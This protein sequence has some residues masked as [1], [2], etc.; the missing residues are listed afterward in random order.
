MNVFNRFA[1]EQ[2]VLN[3]ITQGLSLHGNG[4][5]VIGH[6]KDAALVTWIIKNGYISMDKIREAVHRGICRVGRQM[7]EQVGKIPPDHVLSRE[8][9][10]YAMNFG[11]I[12]P[13]EVASIRFDH[14]ETADEYKSSAGG[15]L[16]KVM[17]QIL[18]GSAFYDLR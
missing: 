16:N 4:V 5:A 2:A 3:A 17:N 10:G 1:V 12:T 7:F 18:E 15:L 13:K 9:L 8:A 11:T 14:G 6:Q